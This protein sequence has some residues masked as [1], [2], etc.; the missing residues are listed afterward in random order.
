MA[1]LP[2]DLTIL[3]DGHRRDAGHASIRGQYSLPNSIASNIAK[4]E[5][6]VHKVV[7]ATIDSIVAPLISDFASAPAV[8]GHKEKYERRSTNVN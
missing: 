8:A 3:R 2:S 4:S 6:A 1:F 5:S 7:T